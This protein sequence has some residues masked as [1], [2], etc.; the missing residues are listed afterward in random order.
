MKYLRPCIVVMLCFAS[1]C[2]IQGQAPVMFLPAELDFF[3]ENIRPLLVSKCIECHGED[4]Q[5]SG[6]RLDSR[7]AILKGAEQQPVVLPGVPDK[8]R[9]LDVLSHMNEVKM[10]PD[11]KLREQ[12]I[13]AVRKWIAMKLP[14]PE[15]ANG[16]RHLH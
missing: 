15:G 2:A 16:S 3:E 14:W 5:E 12:E 1:F 8:S 4:T 13:M 10:P 6:L 7:A 9:L 11:E